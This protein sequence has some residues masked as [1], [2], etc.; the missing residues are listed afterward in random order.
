M[1]TSRPYHLSWLCDRVLQLKPKS[2]LDVGVGFGTKGMLF[3][4]YTD[5]WN[6]DYFDWK[7]K[8]DG[9]E[10]FDKYITPLQ[11]GIYDH[12]YKGNIL[13]VIDTLG[14]YDL[15]YMGDVIEH[16]TKEEGLELLRKLKLR[17]KNL[18]IVTPVE[19]SVQGDIYDNKNEA[20]LSEWSSSD[21]G[22]NVEVI[23]LG[24][25][26]IV[27]WQKPCVYYCD[28]M[29][30]YGERLRK[31]G[32]EE[33]NPT[34][35][36]LFLGLY[37]DEDYRIFRD[38]LGKRYVFWNGSDVTRMLSVRQWRTIVQGTDAVHICHNE[39]LRK[40]LAIA[41]IDAL[42]EP[43]FFGDINS[44]KPSFKSR[45]QLEVYVNAHKMREDEYGIPMVIQAAKRLPDI[46]FFIYGIDDKSNLK[47]VRYMGKLEEELADKK[48]S[49]HHVC[50]R[51]N[52][53][54]GLSQLVIKAGLW[55]HYVLMIKKMKNTIQVRDVLDLVE[56]LEVLKSTREPQRGL[57]P[58]LISK[59]NRF[60][61]L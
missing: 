38:H 19:V 60:T 40:E 20:H 54:D 27:N 43:I 30:F 26:M 48:M 34:R 47:N 39:Q 29:K 37:F 45:E 35:P 33:Y 2:I 1:P 53:H 49:K 3:R 16:L 36:T 52:H 4:E 57:R 31:M 5:V 50:L 51:L 8:I 15:I 13:D 32:F 42:V 10:I 61:W 25:S 55:E 9:V 41:G 24:N 6:G 46:K 7:V 58:W 22:K 21:F 56:K 12:I 44:Y 23:T 28:G 18:I 11:K 14:Y 17:C 59:L